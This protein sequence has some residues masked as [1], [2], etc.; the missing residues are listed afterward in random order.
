MGITRK[1]ALRLLGSAGVATAT[2]LPWQSDSGRPVGVVR[3]DVC[4]IGGGAAGTYAAIRLR[5]QGQRVAVVEPTGR[6]GGHTET[7]HD[8]VTGATI[9]IGVIVWHDEPI[10][11]DYFARFD[12]PLTPLS[13]GGG[14][15]STTHVDFR[16]GLPVPGDVETVPAALGSYFGLLQQYPYL[17]QGFD[18]PD[19]VPAELLIPFGE[20]VIRHGLQSIVRLTF[21]FAQGLGD[22]LRQ[23][24]I[25]VL[26]NFGI[27]VLSNVFAGSFLTTSRH[28]NSELYERATTVLG[29]DALLNTRVVAVDR[30][31]S[32]GVR[33][34]VHGPQGDLIIQADKLLVAFQPL[35]A[36]FGGFDLDRAERSLFD[37]FRPH[38]YWTGVARVAGLAADQSVPNTG[39]A[40]PYNLP[41]LP[42]LYGLSATGVPGLYNIKYGSDVVG[43]DSAVRYSIEADI[44]RLATA[45]TFPGL[46]LQRLETFKSHAPFE[47]TVSPGA[48]ANGFYRSLYGLQGRN[49]TFYTGATFH[50]HDST[51]VWQFTERLLPRLTA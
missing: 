5:D 30:S 15:G 35:A 32:D 34:R 43:S 10:V 49:R 4:V 9:D 39:V 41:K 24:T 48:I 42:G 26:K 50:S 45:G 18:L 13:L 25:Y 22:L 51:L 33:V 37:Q 12:V 17:E 1:D 11:R 46:R 8:P 29:A 44:R 27:G 3:R 28:N 6:L 47:L 16:T 19:P 20:F 14:A 40:T 21:N 7:F 31:R 2:G 23:P 38:G 36:N